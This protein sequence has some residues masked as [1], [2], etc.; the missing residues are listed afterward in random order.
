VPVRSSNIQGSVRASPAVL[1]MWPCKLKL[2]ENDFGPAL[3]HVL[4]RPIKGTAKTDTREK[5]V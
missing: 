3:V 4:L 1:S 5:R 2:D